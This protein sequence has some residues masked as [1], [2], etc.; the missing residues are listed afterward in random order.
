MAA[1]AGEPR[2]WEEDQKLEVLHSYTLSQGT[3]R[4]TCDPVSDKAE[5]GNAAQHLSRIPHNEGLGHGSE[6]EHLP[7]ILQSGSSRGV[8]QR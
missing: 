8:A 2:I 5:D 3:A 1:H 4:A 7:R 6:V